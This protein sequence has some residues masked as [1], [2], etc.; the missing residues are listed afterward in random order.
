MDARD[1][2]LAVLMAAERLDPGA[3]H[4]ALEKSCGSGVCFALTDAGKFCL[5][6]L[7]YTDAE[8]V[9]GHMPTTL[10]DLLLEMAL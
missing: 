8:A 5:L 7:T 10:R 2:K 9:H 1:K 4:R 6:P 3:L